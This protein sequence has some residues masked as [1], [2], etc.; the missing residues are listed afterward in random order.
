MCCAKTESHL[1]IK[2]AEAKE[3]ASQV[4]LGPMR[5]SPPMIRADVII[6]SSP[7][8]KLRPMCRN[9]HG[10]R[11]TPRPKHTGESGRG[12]WSLQAAAQHRGG[13]GWEEVEEWSKGRGRARNEPG[14]TLLP[15]APLTRVQY[16]VCQ[17]FKKYEGQL[18]PPRLRKRT[19]GRRRVSQLVCVFSPLPLPSDCSP[20]PLPNVPLRMGTFSPAP[21]G[22]ALPPPAFLCS[23]RR[24]PCELCTPAHHSL[25]LCALLPPL[26]RSSPAVCLDRPCLHRVCAGSS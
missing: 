17:F 7:P 1:T 9:K 19:E 8:C 26:G 16:K 18:E 2:T 11:V 25:G 15:P 22:P 13:T 23:S 20:P 12:C 10:A 5:V 6:S 4:S 14:P 21:P 3:G 24:A